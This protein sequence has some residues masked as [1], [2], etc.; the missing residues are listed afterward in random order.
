MTYRRPAAIRVAMSKSSPDMEKL[1]EAVLSAQ[2][3]RDSAKSALDKA[4]KA[5]A[6][7]EA[8][9]AKAMVA[10]GE[11][12]TEFGE[13]KFVTKLKVNW[14]SLAAHKEDLLAVLRKEAPEVVKES[15][16]TSTLNKFMNSRESEF[17]SNAPGWWTSVLGMVER[18]EA[19]VLSI[20]KTR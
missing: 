15:V 13:K 8:T 10:A 20:T 19:T 9:L 6:D 3:Q 18:K 4:D 16:H 5:L 2:N 17:A 1:C 11:D 12:E 7:A 14:K